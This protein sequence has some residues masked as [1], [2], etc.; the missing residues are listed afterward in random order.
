MLQRTR[1]KGFAFWATVFW[2]GMGL[3]SAAN[4]LGDEIPPAP[5]MPAHWKVVSDFPVPADQVKAMSG[6]LG[7]DLSSVRN[8]I[9]DVNGKRVQINIIVTPDSGNAEKLMMKLKSM[10]VEEA[11][12]RKELIVYEFA[13]PNDVL[14]VIA[15]GRK[16][17][18]SK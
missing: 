6:R 4:V 11:L 7:A 16:Y 5:Q 2:I 12:L 10:K 9:Y 8:T 3:L 14:P 18:D 17:L 13:G 1:V 15:E